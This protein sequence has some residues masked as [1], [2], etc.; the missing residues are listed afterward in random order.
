MTGNDAKT[1]KTIVIRKADWVVAWDAGTQRHV[2][3]RG[4]D[5]AFRG[6][7]ILHVGPDYDGPADSEVDGRQSVVLPGLI[8]IHCHPY[9]QPTYK[10]VREE[11]GNPKLYMSALYDRTALFQD[12][13]G[14]PEA[15]CA[16]A[17]SEM[18]LTGVTT[19]ADLSPSYE[20]WIDLLA[21]S[22]L[23]AY[24]TPQFREA[25]WDV[26]TGHR[27][28]FVWD[29]AAGQKQFE[30]A[31]AL[32]DEAAAHPSGR[33][34]GIVMPAQVD[35]CSAEM[36][37]ESVKAARARKL[38][39]Q[40]HAAQSVVEFHEMTRRHGLTPIQWLDEVGFLAPDVT[41]GH[42]MFLDHHSLIHWESRSDLPLMAARGVT[43]AHCPTVFSRYGHTLEH[44]GQY[45]QAGV[46]MAIGTDT[47][48]H[49]LWEE[50][51]TAAILARVNAKDFRAVSTADMFNAVTTGPAKAL[52]RE[53][54]GRLAPGAKADIVLVDATH[55]IMRPLRDPLRSLVYTAAERAVR[56][57]YVD[58]V[59]RVEGGQVLTFDFAAAAEAVEQ[60]QRRAEATVAQRNPKGLTGRDISPLAL[61]EM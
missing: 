24:V 12:H 14:G 42:G 51:R 33:L 38:P 44:F 27:L 53:D 29:K 28:D 60:G 55:P 58:G 32:V 54:I 47:H 39:L 17:L 45:L 10:G 43:V 7:T 19:I 59:L 6:N 2:Y 18:L 37:R 52:G 40:T 46:N 25:R 26:P 8:N 34:S 1:A 31:L 30:K 11:L 22:G 13:E 15:P 35:T 61:E 48:P 50:M 41:I 21:K 4:I 23:R 49:N 57:V 16:Y 36:F 56:D 20:G 9:N 3:R 5:I